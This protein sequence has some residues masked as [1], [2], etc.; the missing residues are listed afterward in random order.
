MSIPVNIFFAIF[1]ETI[2]PA[3]VQRVGNVTFSL[4]FFKSLIHGLVIIRV[5]EKAGGPTA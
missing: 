3:H 2:L 1:D 5:I 4:R